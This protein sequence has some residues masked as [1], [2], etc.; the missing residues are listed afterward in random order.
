M[1]TTATEHTLG[2][3]PRDRVLHQWA[4]MLRSMLDDHRREHPADPRSNAELIHQ[5]LAGWV[6]AGLITQHGACYRIGPLT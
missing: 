3:G 1:S 5:W 4:A 2:W 6:R